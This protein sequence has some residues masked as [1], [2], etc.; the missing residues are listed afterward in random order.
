MLSLIKNILAY[1]SALIYVF[2]HGLAK[3]FLISGI[4]S[5]LIGGALFGSIYYFSDDIGGLLSGLYPF[6]WGSSA[7]SKFS[8]YLTGGIFLVFGLLLYK[9]LLLI[10]ISPFMSPLSERVETIETG[11]EAPQQ[12]FGKV[13]Y[14]L[15]RG[16]GISL[17]N[18][19]KELIYTIII[20][21]LGLI[22]IFSPF[23]AVALFIVQ[24]YYIGFANM[25]YHLEKRNTIKQ[26]VTFCKKNRMAVLG[27]GIG[28]LL[29]LFIP[30]IGLM[31]APVLGTVS[32]T[33]NAL[34]SE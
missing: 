4:I 29:L 31:V 5:L 13:G 34:I 18:V 23:A 2:K 16:I 28:Y 26:S 8:T 6:E 24:A 9:Y 25:D 10:L 20:L 14:S 1:P 21:L 19:S 15:V 11:R 32:A 17:R 33:R 12:G 22:P 3:Y 27:N 7:I 30:V